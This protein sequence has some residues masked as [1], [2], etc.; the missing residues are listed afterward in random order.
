MAPSLWLKENPMID[1]NVAAA[2][3]LVEDQE[4]SAQ[5]ACYEA[6][7][8]VSVAPEAADLCEDAQLKCPACPWRKNDSNPR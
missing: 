7:M 4:A 1:A 2:H 6:A 3:R 5:Q 8:Q